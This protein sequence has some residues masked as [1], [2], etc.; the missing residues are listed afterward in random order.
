MTPNFPKLLDRLTI[1]FFLVLT[2]LPFLA[3]AGTSAI[4]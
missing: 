3:V 2:A 1:S 4:H